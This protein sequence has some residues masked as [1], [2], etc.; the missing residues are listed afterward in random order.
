MALGSDFDFD[1][2]SDE[3]LFEDF[4]MRL[5]H[6]RTHAHPYP[7]AHTYLLDYMLA[8]IPFCAWNEM[9]G[10]AKASGWMDGWMA[11]CLIERIPWDEQADLALLSIDLTLH[12]TARIRLDHGHFLFIYFGFSYIS[13]PVGNLFFVSPFAFVRSTSRTAYHS[14]C[15]DWEGRRDISL[16]PSR[17][18]CTSKQASVYAFVGFVSM[19]SCVSTTHTNI[20]WK[21][22]KGW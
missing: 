6:T 22:A 8:S 12:D 15:R 2:D 10:R 14:H 19:A 7:R 16:S 13:G 1:F 3:G 9:A 5:L 17:W 11:D 4:E 18:F 20:R 21:R